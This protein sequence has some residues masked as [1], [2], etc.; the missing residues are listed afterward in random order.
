MKKKSERT[1]A[2]NAAVDKTYQVKVDEEYHGQQLQDVR[3]GVHDM[4]QDVLHEARGE[5]AGNDLGRVVIHHDG[6]HDPII[7][8]LQPWDTL[9]AEKV[10]ETIQKVLNSNQTLSINHS[11]DITIGTIDLPKGGA[12]KRITRIKGKKNSLDLKKSIVT[13]ENDDNLCMARAI[14][15]CWAKL[16]RCTPEE[17][18]EV[19]KQRQGKSNLQLVLEHQKVPLTYYNDIVNKN[20]KQQGQLAATLC[21][22]AGVPMDRAASLQDIEAFEELLGVRVMVVSAK[23]GKK[24]ITN[25]ST[26]ERSCIYVYLVDDDHFHAITSITGFFS[27]GYFCDKCLYHYNNK[28]RH[29]CD[30][31]CM[32]C[33]RGKC[34][35]TDQPQ[36]CQDCNMDCRSQECFDKHK[37]VPLHKKGKK[38]GQPR[39]PS[40][41]QK[42]WKCL[43]CY[44]V[45][46]TDI[47]KKEEHECGEY[48]C[49]A[50]EQ[51]VHEGH[52]CYLR[53][54]ECKEEFIPKFIF[55]DF[56]C[57]Q[58]ER[59][60]CTQGY[61]PNRKTNCEHCQEDV[62]CKECSICKHCKTSMCGKTT[63]VPNFVVA[64]TVCPE[65]IDEELTPDAV[66]KGCGTRCEECAKSPE[67]YDDE[68][69]GP[70]PGT[71]GFRE[72][73]FEGDDTAT[74][75]GEWLFSD[76]HEHFKAIAHNM[77][78]YDGYFLLEYL[79]DQSVRP[80]KVIYSGSKIMY[81]AVEKDLHI[82]VI[83]SLNFLPMKL[84]ALP[85]AFGLQELKK[86]WFPH[87][88]NTKD[89]QHYRGAF[90]EARHYG[91]DFM[92]QEERNALLDWLEE[93]KTEIFDFR[94]EMLAYCRS[95]VDIL[96][97]ACLKFRV[98]LMKATG[99]E[100]EVI[101]DKGKKT[102]KWVRAIDPFDSV[103][104]AS[105]CMNVFRTKFLEETWQVRLEGTDEWIPA[106]RLDGKLLVWDND[107]WVPQ[108]KLRKTVT[109]SQ[110]ISTPIAKI[111]PNGYQDQYSRVSIQWLEWMAHKNG[112]HIQHALNTGEKRIP[113]TRYKLDG[114]SEDT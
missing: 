78:G 94:E 85:K 112:I 80:D 84:S 2:K 111:P 74:R 63:H 4:I 72:I 26:D 47:R 105:V 88:F 113:G 12:R 37:E 35:K 53:A 97:Q 75:F 106:K 82:Q 36:T 30:T 25:P 46:R 49:S 89:H 61:S 33:K 54:N 28:E 64:H 20:L 45:V 91:H 55:F 83:D 11:F 39:G 110:F 32:V 31:S 29:D 71:C 8:P 50:C 22:M 101:D 3:E 40:Q 103:T 95:D 13:I 70:C 51:Y 108:E 14:G 98:L 73:V 66:C 15:V 16:K 52:L 58:D 5:L 104:I 6:L 93:K 96:R 18:K 57:R 92:S 102:K 24:F 100:V 41:C 62:P 59:A 56:E 1:Y 27:A 60:Q 69:E 86:G 68:D 87:F 19:T 90:P 42:Y 79:I 7:V 81:M 21:R 114:Y 17:W 76:Q 38:K 34:P 109:E 99:E 9:N 44:K 77:K 23:L 10:M 65:C 107:Q 48:W 67:E 43:T